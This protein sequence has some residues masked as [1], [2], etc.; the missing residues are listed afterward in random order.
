M[1]RTLLDV[2]PAQFSQESTNTFQSV[3]V[4]DPE[5]ELINL[6]SQEENAETDHAESDDVESKNGDSVQE[7]REDLTIDFECPICF[8]ELAEETGCMLPFQCGHPVCDDCYTQ[9]KR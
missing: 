9:V 1:G 7:V 4:F 2:E 3:N 8:N 6:D 5:D